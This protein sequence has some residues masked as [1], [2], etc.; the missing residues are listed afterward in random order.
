MLSVVRSP[1]AEFGGTEEKRTRTLPLGMF[2]PREA[3]AAA[4]FLL[5]GEVVFAP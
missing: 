4:Q 3:T 5:G 1:T 2:A